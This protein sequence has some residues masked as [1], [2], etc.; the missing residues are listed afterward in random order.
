MKLYIFL[1]SLLFLFCS[2]GVQAQFTPICITK[3]CEATELSIGI[4]PLNPKEIVCG[5]SCGFFTSISDSGRTWRL[6]TN[7]CQALN[8][9]ENPLVFWRNAQPFQAFVNAPDTITM[10]GIIASS[11]KSTEQDC[12]RTKLS[13]GEVIKG[14]QIHIDESTQTQY[15]VWTQFGI[16]ENGKQCDSSLIMYASSK[17]QNWEWNKAVRISAFAGDCSN[18]DSTLMGAAICTG[19]NHE[20][21]ATW[22]GPLG[23]MFK[24]ISD[25]TMKAETLLLPLKNGWRGTIGKDIPAN[26]LPTIACDNSNSAYKGRIYICWSDERHGPSNK[27]VFLIYSDNQGENWT[28][29]IV[30]TYLPNHKEQFMPLMALDQSTGQVYILYFDQQNYV[31]GDA[32]DLYLA[33]S[34]NGGLKFSYYKVNTTPILPQKR[35][36]F[37]YSLGLSVAN[38][39]VRPIWMQ[40]NK[41]GSADIY[42]ALI[43]A[44]SLLKY[45]QTQLEGIKISK[46]FFW[47]EKMPITFELKNNSLVS[48]TITKPLEPGTEKIIF[49]NKKMQKGK[50]SF[51]I[52][53]KKSG[54]KKGIYTLTLYYNQKNTFCW[55]VEE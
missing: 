26:G 47:S 10:A 2:K 37:G 55:I 30:V 54:L 3:N 8:R 33:Q 38:Q 9:F 32:C 16:N 42:T 27:N 15:A 46:T 14:L 29:P 53:T 19:P 31:D 34:N 22:A 17:T 18:G 45:D 7:K 44:K 40:N 51:V 36:D 52:D 21:Y 41:A 23:L 12:N 20:V 50:N 1:P 11:E 6:D 28:E 5:S 13:R 25:S 39:I 48:A 4:N 43:D 49:K 35:L 24:K